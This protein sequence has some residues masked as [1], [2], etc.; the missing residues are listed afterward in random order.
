MWKLDI[1]EDYSRSPVATKEFGGI[2]ELRIALVENAGKQ[3][4]IKPPAHTT[5]ADRN[6]LLDLRGQGFD[7]AMRAH[8]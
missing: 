3:F 4:V 1:Y 5:A 7:I 2:A 8:D 6:A